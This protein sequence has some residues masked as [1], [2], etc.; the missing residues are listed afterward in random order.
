MAIAI[1]GKLHITANYR[2]IDRFRGKSEH[3]Q[4]RKRGRNTDPLI[5]EETKFT[6]F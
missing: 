3:N 4:A 5:D 1:A 6:I 2:F